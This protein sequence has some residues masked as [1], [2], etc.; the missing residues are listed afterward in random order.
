[1]RAG[2]TVVNRREKRSLKW[3]GRNIKRLT[4]SGQKEYFSGKHQEENRGET[5]Q[6]L[7]REY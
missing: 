3:F 6:L 2:E 5:T 1:M 4:S 7:E